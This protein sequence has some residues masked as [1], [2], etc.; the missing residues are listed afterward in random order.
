VAV[1][2]FAHDLRYTVRKLVRAPMFTTVAVLTLAVGIGSNAAIFS[3]VNGVLLKPLPFE[4]PESLVGIW[5]TAPGL[6]FEEINQSPA[7]HFTYASDSRTFA[8]VGMWDNASAS[9][10]GLEE[11]EQVP[12]M[13]VTH[14]TLPM[15]GVPPRL[16]RTFTP[17][18]DTPDGT[19]TVLLGHAYWRDRFG[20]DPAILG[21]TMV[22]NGVSREIIGVMPADFRFL[23]YDPSLY[24]PF[25]FDEGEVFMGNFSY[26]ALGR[27]N[28]GATV[29]QANADVERMV[30]IAIERYPGGLTLGMLQEAQFGGLVRPLKTDV[31]GDVGSVLWV[32]LGT[33][34]IVLLI[35]CA[36]V[37][38]L[39]IV[40]AEG[41]NREIAVR[42]AMGA[43]RRQV[44][45]QLLLESIVLGIAG[46]IAGLGLA[47]AGLK[48]LVALGPEGL[49]RL[50]EIGLDPIVLAFTV[51][52]AIVSGLFFG[53][54]PALQYGRPNLTAS[55]KEGGR[56]GSAGRD[57]HLARNGLV[58]AQM[59][60]ALVLLAG[61]GL[62]VRSFQ[63]LNDVDP[64][65]DDPA[66]LLS[67][68]VTIPTA[69]VE[70]VE[71]VARTHQEILRRV[72][73]VPGVASAAFSSSVAMDGWDSN[74][75]VNVEE[76]P[77]EG[78]QLPPI[79]RFKYVGAGYHETMGIEVL[80]GRAITWAEIEDRA[81]V[82]MVTA[83][84]VE[85]YWSSPAEAVGKRISQYG[86]SFGQGNWMEIVGVVQP[87]YDDGVSRE[88]VAT[89]YWPQVVEDWWEED[90]Y[91]PRSVAYAVRAEAGDPGA[92]IPQIRSAVWSVNPNLPLARVSKLKEF[93]DE[94]MARTSFT[95]I[96][97]GIAAGVALFLGAVGVYGVIS[98]VVAQRTREIGVRMA[99][100]AEQAT[101]RRMVLKQGA[102]LAAGGVL[103]GLVAAAG[104]TRLM[105]S[106]LFGVEPIDPPTFAAVA[107]SLSVI[108]LLATW[109]PA[110]RASAVDPVV[111]L[112]FE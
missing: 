21:K 64:G 19:Q 73:A 71:E 93:M 85:D 53:L 13:Y 103:V 3:V 4:D 10:T 107:L 67:F 78:E 39:F 92:L 95:L 96:M 7:L 56:G 70:D 16:G 65:F 99:L 59:S 58:V 37:A 74:D 34:A 38:N 84:F 1:D 27:L 98:Y 29:E 100:G 87:V 55:L 97:L 2:S 57:R 23:R 63:A 43:G 94:S 101:V 52:V 45:G 9:V 12:V 81:P 104:V 86:G 5:H 108:A 31:V 42:T 17:E 30:P 77:V 20:S 66:G 106:L 49:P 6:G 46:G 40:R 41:R 82:V 48:L 8:S 18:E 76:F 72:A 69:E 14:Q 15:L 110:R 102:A 112:R 60:L 22:V 54:F 47:F 44:T 28:P 24:L 109:I 26:Q 90:V 75:A 50:H 36:N 83:D 68:R 25:R 62:M 89:V 105:A 61:S 51:T 111:A 79:R 91:S 88:S 11:P 32:L 33:V 35:A 80:A